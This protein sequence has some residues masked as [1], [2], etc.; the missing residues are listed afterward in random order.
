MTTKQI[1]RQIAILKNKLAKATTK[2]DPTG[3]IC[4]GLRREIKRLEAQR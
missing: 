2:P 3:E 4:E 1:Q